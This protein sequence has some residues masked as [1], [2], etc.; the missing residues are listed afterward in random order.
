M[1]GLSPTTH[2]ALGS[3][4]P[5]FCH[6][7]RPLQLSQNVQP[8]VFSQKYAE[9]L[10]HLQHVPHTLNKECNVED[11]Y[12]S[13]TDNTTHTHQYREETPNESAMSLFSINLWLSRDTDDGARTQTF[14]A[15]FG[16]SAKMSKVVGFGDPSLKR[17]ARSVASGR[18]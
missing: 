13:R 7:C 5:L 10:T 16:S 4:H 3:V 14:D 12:P 18:G 1:S 2:R 8:A 11:E 6:R 17:S 15:H 9:Y